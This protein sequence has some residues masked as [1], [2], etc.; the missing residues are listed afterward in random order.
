MERM[1]WVKAKWDHMNLKWRD[2]RDVNKLWMRFRKVNSYWDHMV[3]N[4]AI[5]SIKREEFPPKITIPSKLKR[6]I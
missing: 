2:Y 4:D 1:D 5:I 3:K 6:N